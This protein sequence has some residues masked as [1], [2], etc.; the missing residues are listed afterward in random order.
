MKK[1]FFLA[2]LSII[3]LPSIAR[4][5]DP[6]APVAE[7][8]FGVVYVKSTLPSSDVITLTSAADPNSTQTI[9]A[10]TDSK[11][12]VGDY[13]VRVEMQEYSYEV[14][15]TIRPTERH[16]I[17]V[18]G[19]GNLRVNGPNKALV[20][21]FEANSNKLVT[22]FQTNFTKTLPRGNYDVKVSV[23]KTKKDSVTQ[24][25]VMVV[26]NTT[27]QVDVKF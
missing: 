22:K 16:E 24:K 1:L 17:I 6:V 4:A 11:V 19:F 27:R 15:V 2:L 25:N 18:P 10:E 26:T 7:R 14:E 20:E 21:V 9:K 12:A 13:T 8:K 3:S 23:G 5:L